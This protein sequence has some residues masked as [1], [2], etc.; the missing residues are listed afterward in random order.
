MKKIVLTLATLVSLQSCTSEQMTDNKEQA[1]FINSNISQKNVELY[2]G[3]RWM[4][5]LNNNT[6]IGKLSIPGTHDSMSIKNYAFS[7]NQYGTIEEQLGAGA[8]I[9]DLRFNFENGQFMG[10]HGIVRLNLTLEQVMATFEKFLKNNPNEFIVAIFKK[11]NNNQEKESWVKYYNEKMHNYAQL[12]LVMEQWNSNNKLVDCRGKV[13]PMS[14]ETYTNSTFVQGWSGNPNFSKT[15]LI[16][17][18]FYNTLNISDYYHVSTIL[19]A[20]INYKFEKI[21]ENID[22]ANGNSSTHDAFLTYCSGAST[23]AYPVAVADRVNPKVA[24]YIQQSN[25]KSAG[26]IMMDFINSEKGNKLANSCIQTS[27]TNFSE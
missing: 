9:F 11:E 19:G 12:G 21:K 18:G 17:N 5:K 20:S 13:L 27:I 22:R 10:Y 1:Q 15:N 25:L 8:R 2:S 6:E 7:S 3:S 14:R 26:W 24:E 23:F 16:G 4:E